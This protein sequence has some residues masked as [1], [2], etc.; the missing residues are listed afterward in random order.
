MFEDWE[1]ENWGIEDDI[2][3][4]DVESINYANDVKELAFGYLKE[5][6]FN[7]VETKMLHVYF[8]KEEFDELL[9]DELL[10]N[11]I[12]DEWLSV[13]YEN[14]YWVVDFSE[15]LIQICEIQSY[16]EYEDTDV[17]MCSY[18]TLSEVIS[19]YKEKY[20][21]HYKKNLDRYWKD[22]RD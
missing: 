4:S 20:S 21:K 19:E 15:L 7:G 18:I 1:E 3:Q 8:T 9:E 17:D 11:I 5:L 12:S 6:I 2:F 14:G 16:K 22:V 13:G 10:Q